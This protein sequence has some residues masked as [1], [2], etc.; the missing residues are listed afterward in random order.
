P[1][2]SYSAMIGPPRMRRCWQARPCTSR[3]RGPRSART[4]PRWSRT[5][6]RVGS[7]PAERAEGGRKAPHGGADGGSDRSRMEGM[8]IRCYIPTTLN[9]L[10]SGLPGAR[11]V[12]PDERGRSLRGEEFET[13]EFDAMCIA[14]A[15]AASS[16][17]DRIIGGASSGESVAD[18]D[19]DGAGEARVVIAYDAPESSPRET[20]TEGFD[21]IGLV[22]VDMTAVAS[23][24]LDEDAVWNDAVR[25]ALESGAEAAEDRLGESD[26]LWYDAT[27]LPSLLGERG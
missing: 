11:A 4:S 3:I 7:A 5:W 13:V 23:F 20:L 17:L 27:E 22:H 2:T 15:L 14:A 6:H 10:R 16:A 12:A 26:L 18:S 24:H 8:T 9:A 1:P 21:L 19:G 25:L